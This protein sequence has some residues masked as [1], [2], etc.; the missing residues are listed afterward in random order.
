MRTYQPESSLKLTASS[1]KMARKVMYL[2]FC[3]VRVV[4]FF[5]L[6]SVCAALRSIFC[7]FFLL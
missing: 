7:I 5:L 3:V 6:D 1:E 2:Y 4:Y